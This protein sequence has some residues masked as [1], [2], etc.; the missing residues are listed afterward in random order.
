MILSV[1]GRL[2]YVKLSDMR[3]FVW[4]GLLRLAGLMRYRLGL[5]PQFSDV[6][7]HRLVQLVEGPDRLAPGRVVDLG[8]GT[9]RNSIYL[10]RNGWDTIG[11]DMVGHALQ[12]ARRKAAAQGLTV[13]FVQGNVTRLADLDIGA[14]FD[15][16]MDG[17]C[18]QMI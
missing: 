10:A 15:L 12:T 7:D 17:G 6:P 8:C 4:D 2:I 11:V 13:Q 18:Y 1:S 9:G 14:D 3:Q 16:L 5:A